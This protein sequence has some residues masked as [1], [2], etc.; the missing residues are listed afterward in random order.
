MLPRNRFE[1]EHGFVKRGDQFIV[2]EDCVYGEFKKGDTL[3][4]VSIVGDGVDTTG[5][6]KKYTNIRGGKA[7]IH[8]MAR[9]VE[10]V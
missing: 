1:R 9:H 6:S 4:A 3:K 5:E 8:I 7:R 2:V 10:R